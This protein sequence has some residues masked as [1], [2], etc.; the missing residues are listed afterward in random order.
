MRVDNLLLSILIDFNEW[1]LHISHD[2][3]RIGIYNWFAFVIETVEHFNVVNLVKRYNV[4]IATARKW[5][6]RDDSQDRSHRLH[7]LATTLSAAQE[8]IVV[9]LRRMLLLPLDDLLAVIREFINLDVSR[10]GL[11]RCLRRHKV[12]LVVGLA[13]VHRFIQLYE[14]WEPLSDRTRILHC[15]LKC[16]NAYHCQTLYS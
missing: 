4:S 12:S 1:Q 7:T 11:D 14:C 3:I 15:Y 13:P 6:G 8:L 10:S 9:E 2:S 5:K 16:S